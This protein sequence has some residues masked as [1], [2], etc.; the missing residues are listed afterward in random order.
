MPTQILTDQ[1]LFFDGLKLTS[2]TTAMDLNYAVEGQNDTTF[3][4]TTASEKGG[5]KIVEFGASGF[6]DA[7]PQDQVLF[8]DV[9]LDDKPCSI[10]ANSAEG[11]RAF[12]FLSTLGKY[13]PIKGE[14]G[15]MIGF[16]ISAAARGNL[17]RGQL[18]CNQAAIAASGN[19][20]PY[21][22]GA[23]TSGQIIHAA[24]HVF[25]VSG[26]TPTIDVTISSDNAVGFSS[27]ITRFTF[28][29][30]NARGSQYLTLPGAITDD[31]WRVNYTV[32][33]TTPSFGVAVVLGIV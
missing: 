9:G 6:F 30:M 14:V 25:S 33:G 16:D 20:S 15:D 31:Y 3:G 18:I 19:R 7:T 26:T 10:A 32:G 27:P 24:L 17:V 22:V 11:S 23:A 29:Q 5:L 12:T 13:S 28:A 4:D 21:Q 8:G 1:E 2:I